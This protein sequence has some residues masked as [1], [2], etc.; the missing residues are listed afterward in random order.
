MGFTSRSVVGGGA[1]SV[2]C[3]QPC[4][5]TSAICAGNCSLMLTTCTLIS[6]GKNVYEQIIRHSGNKE[7]AALRK[8]LRRLTRS[9]EARITASAP[10]PRV[11]ASTLARIESTLEKSLASAHE[12]LDLARKAKRDFAVGATGSSRRNR[13]VNG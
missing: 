3:P 2:A 13:E 12:R 4:G 8:Q 5:A 7:L 1:Q 9:V 6:G 10:P 11:T